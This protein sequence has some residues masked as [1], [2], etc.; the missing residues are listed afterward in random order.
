[1]IA[2]DSKN[3]F[4]LKQFSEADLCIKKCWTYGIYLPQLFVRFFKLS[5][6]ILS[7]LVKWSNDAINIKKLTP[8]LDRMDFLV[9]VYLDVTT[10]KSKIPT[11]LETIIDKMPIQLNSQLS[12]VQKSFED[13]Q[14]EFDKCLNDVKK[15]WCNEIIAQT[16]GWSKQ[17][18]D[19]PRLYRKTN[20]DAPTKPCNYVEQILK[21]AKLFWRKNSKQISHG[22]LN[23]CLITA[24]SHLNR[25]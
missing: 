13:S 11:I 15:C 1:M 21:P 8:N 17:V 6:Q 18:A 3:S 10:L 24:F 4:R 20:R 12:I 7:R 19:I 16:T 23:E 14:N 9:L 22:T 25:Q 5:L 2:S